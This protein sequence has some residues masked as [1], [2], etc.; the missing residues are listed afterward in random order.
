MS[1]VTQFSGQVSLDPGSTDIA[2]LELFPCHLFEKALWM[3]FTGFVNLGGRLTVEELRSFQ[4][5]SSQQNGWA[6]EGEF[7]CRFCS[8]REL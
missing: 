6:L 3:T 1:K 7:W 8:H 5:R 2:D 4:I